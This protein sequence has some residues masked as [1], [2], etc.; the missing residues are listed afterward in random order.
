MSA[1][2]LLASSVVTWLLRVGF[3]AIVPARRIPQSL[4]RVLDHA[5]VAALAALLATAL[6]RE[7]GAAWFLTPSPMHVAAL[8]AGVVAWR[9]R[10][11]GL[12]VVVA[13]A[14][15]WAAQLFA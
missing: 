1:V 12:T 14:V 3:I 6:A 7:G 2:V 5:A 11:L 4:R 10:R 15:L 8:V 9:T 13:I